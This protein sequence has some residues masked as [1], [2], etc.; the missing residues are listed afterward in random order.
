MKN[1][2]ADTGYWIA[3]VNPRDNLRQKAM[4]VSKALGSVRVVTSELVLAELLNTFAGRG[5]QS[6][7]VAC[8][9]VDEILSNAN[10]EVISVSSVDFEN[11]RSMYCS[12]SDKEWSVTDCASFQIMAARGITDALAAD[13]HFEQAGFRALLADHA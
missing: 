12:R 6:R 11:A 1:V 9:V 8:Q 5:E 3:L 4:A 2:F 10:A 7:R 13:H